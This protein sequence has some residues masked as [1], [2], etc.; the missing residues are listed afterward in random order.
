MAGLDLVA[1]QLR[2]TLA[3]HG[4]EEIEVEPGTTFD[5]EYHEAI[6]TQA[7]R[8]VRRGHGDP[9]ARAR[10]PAARQAAAAGQGHR[11]QLAGGDG[12]LL[13]DTRSLQERLPGRDQEGV[14]QAG[15]RAPPGQEPRQHGGGGEVQGGQHGLR[16]ALRPREAQAVRRAQPARRLRR[17]AGRRRVPARRRRRAGLR[18]AAVQRRAEAPSSRWATSATSSATCSAARRAAPAAAAA[19]RPSGAT[20]C[21]PTSPSRSTTR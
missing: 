3:G 2:G 14:P 16:D 20:T 19:G 15:A 21:R 13:S 6:M 4:L 5:P 1:D 11:G 7:V 17:G 8:R 9:G 18:P 12:R 10:L